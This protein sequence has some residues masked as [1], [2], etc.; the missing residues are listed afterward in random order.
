MNR[1]SLPR[2]RPCRS[3][4]HELCARVDKIGIEKKHGDFSNL[5][6]M[7][8]P[9]YFDLL[10][11]VLFGLILIGSVT[12]LRLKKHSIVFLMFFTLF[13]VYL[14]KVLDYTLIQFQS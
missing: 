12:F 10:T 13:Y 14:Y 2:Q 7:G 11:V 3:L 6:A 5:G 1:R 8:F 9:Q 4:A